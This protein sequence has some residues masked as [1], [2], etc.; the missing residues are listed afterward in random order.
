MSSFF[1]LAC[2][3][4]LIWRK[5]SFVLKDALQINFAE[6]LGKALSLYEIRS[7]K[8]DK[9]IMHLFT[10]IIIIIIITS[11]T[12]KS[13]HVQWQQ[14]QLLQVILKSLHKPINKMD[15]QRKIRIALTQKKTTTS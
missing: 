13:N 1:Y 2:Y 15:L 3:I 6:K 4:D 7:T 12:G 10:I 9:F 14:N 11:D 8:Q 5:V